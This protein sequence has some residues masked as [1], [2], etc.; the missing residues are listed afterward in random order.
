MLLVDALASLKNWK[1]TSPNNFPTSFLGAN[2]GP[3]VLYESIL[4]KLIASVVF[5]PKLPLC[6]FIN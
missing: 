1:G 4:Q 5:I 3:G 2:V 6:G